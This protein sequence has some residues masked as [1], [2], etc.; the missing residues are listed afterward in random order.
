MHPYLRAIIA[1]FIALFANGAA[2][3]IASHAAATIKEA[4][5]A[6]F[7]G[8]IAALF[9]S[10]VGLFALVDAATCAV[11]GTVRTLRRA[12]ER[13][14]ARSSPAEQPH[15]TPETFKRFEPVPAHVDLAPISIEPEPA[16]AAAP[17]KPVRLVMREPSGKVVG[18]PL[19]DPAKI[20]HY[21]AKYEQRGYR[22]LRTEPL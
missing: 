11:Y 21:R 13:K 18:L 6:A 16:P 9:V 10:A 2:F 15:R 5:G 19:R 3:I 8:I 12:D 22:F 7:G 14:A 20:D 17:G 4:P 1:M